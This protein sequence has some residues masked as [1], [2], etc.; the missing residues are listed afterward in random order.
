MFFNVLL[1]C[2]KGYSE[3]SSF[4]PRIGQYHK[5]NQ[6]ASYTNQLLLDTHQIYK[7]FNDGHEVLYLF[8]DMLKTYDKVW[9]KGL[10]FKLK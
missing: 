9:H 5:T 7:S 6:A 8:L 4:S 2:L 10:I 1:F 3:T